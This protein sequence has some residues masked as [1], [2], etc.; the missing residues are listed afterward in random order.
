[1]IFTN[2]NI[3][4]RHPLICFSPKIYTISQC[5]KVFFGVNLFIW[6]NINFLIKF[7]IISICHT[8]QYFLRHSI[9]LFIHINSIQL[10]FQ[11]TKFL[12]PSSFVR[13]VRRSPATSSFAT[14]YCKFSHFFYKFSFH[15]LSESFP[16]IR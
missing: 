16:T 1:M 5:L 10:S 9:L 15:S 11:L 3:F 13:F 2:N 8:Y 12:L 4:G 7:D 6:K 14:I